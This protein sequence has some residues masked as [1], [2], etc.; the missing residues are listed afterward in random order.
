MPHPEFLFLRL[1]PQQLPLIPDSDSLAL[2]KVAFWK[3]FSQPPRQT[4][5]WD[6]TKKKKR[7]T[8]LVTVD[9]F[10][11]VSAAG[12]T[13]LTSWRFDRDLLVIQLI[14]GQIRIARSNLSG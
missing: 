2:N 11:R 14:L 6:K 9:V 8:A 1:F 4:L 7:V 13:A 10:R 5:W 12:R 3:G